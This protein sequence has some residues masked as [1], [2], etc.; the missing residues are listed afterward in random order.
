MEERTASPAFRIGVDCADD[1]TDFV[2]VRRNC[3]E[4]SETVT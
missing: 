3:G 2:V 4:R 1:I